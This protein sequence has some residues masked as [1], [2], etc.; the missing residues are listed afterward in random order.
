[1]QSMAPLHMHIIS[2]D[3]QSTCLKNKKHWN[4]FNTDYFIELNKLIE[5]LEE[6]GKV[7][8]Y[9]SIIDRF[10]LRKPEKLEAYLKLDLKCH[11][12]EKAMKNM[13]ELKKHLDTSH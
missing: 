8:D 3:F 9:F 12:C 1:M 7:A 6:L 4:S 5:H 11:M 13:P 2:R 10:N